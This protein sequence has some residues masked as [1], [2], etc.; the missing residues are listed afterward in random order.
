M[1]LWA[2]ATLDAQLAPEVLAECTQAVAAGLGA[3]SLQNT[4]NAVWGLALLGALPS[5]LWEAAVRHFEACLATLDGSGEL[6]AE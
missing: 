5:S 6:V 1:S 3:Y 4:A 2:L